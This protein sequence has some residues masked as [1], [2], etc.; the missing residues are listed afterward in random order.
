LSGK[1]EKRGTVRE[2]YSC[3]G[4]VRDFSQNQGNA[5]EKILSSEIAQKLS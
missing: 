3:A 1:Q 4:N 2:F 5:K